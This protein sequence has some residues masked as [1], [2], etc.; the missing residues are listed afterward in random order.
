[1]D[2]IQAILGMIGDV[3]IWAVFAYLFIDERK[4]HEASREAHMEDLRDMA[5]MRPQ[6]RHPATSPD[7]QPLP[8]MP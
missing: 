3:G 2:E 1:M 7:T 5:G 8:D 4:R 6:L